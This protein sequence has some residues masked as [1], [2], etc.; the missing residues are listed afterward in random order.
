VNR[1]T[2]LPLLLVAL[3][4]PGCSGV[5]APPDGLEHVALERG[6]TILAP[7][8]WGEVTV[9]AIEAD[10]ASVGLDMDGA[11]PTLLARRSAEDAGFGLVW[12]SLEE[13]ALAHP[14]EII[15]S[16][17][18]EVEES[19]RA[20]A[21]AE[22]DGLEAFGR[23]LLEYVGSELT[24]IGPHLALHVQYRRNGPEGPVYVRSYR[25]FH[26]DYMVHMGLSYRESDADR[27]ADLLDQVAESLRLG[28]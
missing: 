1:S 25:V 28:P 7:T 12:I 27:Y 16:P 15:Q 8:G 10:I 21:I 24:R 2:A 9:Q 14:D 23:G 19:G 13:P 4:P 3:F 5:P 17:V 6:I 26:A 22:S 18:D 11:L 20:I